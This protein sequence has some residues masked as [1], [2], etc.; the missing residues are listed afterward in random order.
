VEGGIW[1][2]AAADANGNVYVIT[3]NG[4]FDADAS[5][6]GG[7]NYGDTFLKF[8]GASIPVSDY[9]TPFNQ[10]ALAAANADLGSG[11]ALLLPDQPVVPGPPHLMVGAGKQG[12]VYLV[13]RDNMGKFQAG[14]D[15]QIVQWFPG[16]AC[17]TGSCAIFGTPAYFNNTVYTV[18]VQD[19]L[20]A[21]SL[22]AGKL[23]L[24]PVQSPNTF[25]FPG[26][27]PV[28]SA[29]GSNNGIV[30][31]LETNGSGAPAVLH[32]Y[33]AAGVSTELYNSNQNPGR[34]SPGPAVKFTVPTVANG[35]V[36]VGAQGQLS[37]FGIL[38]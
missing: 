6:G 19:G 18:A 28:I 31:A 9:F 22:V 13:N 16:G 5:L 21:Y 15:S 33:P 34:D 24:P 26:A 8:T 2:G 37:V 17:G 20:K 27:T 14:S 25:P 3:S 30:W 10:A 1:G 7:N 36:Y 35:K 4:T 32:A 11:G 38:P 29:S 12:I 23:S